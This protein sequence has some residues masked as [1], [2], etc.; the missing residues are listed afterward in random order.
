ME[1]LNW[2]GE[3]CAT[4]RLGSKELGW[5][6]FLSSQSSDNFNFWSLQGKKRTGTYGYVLKLWKNFVY[7]SLEHREGIYFLHLWNR[8]EFELEEISSY[9]QSG[10][11][12]IVVFLLQSYVCLF[13]NPMDHSPPGFSVHWISWARILEWVAISF[14]KGSSWPRDRTR[15]S[16]TNKWIFTTESTGKPRLYDTFY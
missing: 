1:P 6:S 11:S 3:A 2:T 14:S 15:V 8:K 4:Y 5:Y 10:F 9:C 7:S 16:C 12:M 13:C